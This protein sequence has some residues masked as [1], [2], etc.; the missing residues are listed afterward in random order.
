MAF[1]EFF[2]QSASGTTEFFHSLFPISFRLLLITHGKITN[3]N[4]QQC[5]RRPLLVFRC[6]LIVCVIEC[7]IMLD[8]HSVIAFAHTNFCQIFQRFQISW[9]VL[10][11]H[12]FLDGGAFC[13]NLNGFIILFLSCQNL[14]QFCQTDGIFRMIFAEMFFQKFNGFPAK[15]CRRL[16]FP[17]FLLH[18]RQKL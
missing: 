16:T 13:Q 9:I 12:F 15:S 6:F 17:R 3:G 4:C 5:F 18:I 14:T 2:R 8:C 10:I 1:C 11:Q 7:Q